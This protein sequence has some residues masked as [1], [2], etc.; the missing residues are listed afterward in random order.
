MDDGLWGAYH[1]DGTTVYNPK[2]MTMPEGT[3][4]ATIHRVESSRDWYADSKHVYY[5]NRLLP[6]AN[7]KTFFN[8]FI[9]LFR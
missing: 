9:P 8:I 4:F 1:T 2:L 3:D 6:G 7:P 5:E